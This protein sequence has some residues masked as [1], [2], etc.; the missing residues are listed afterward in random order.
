M[1]LIQMLTSQLGVSEGQ[2][3]GASGLIFKMA[4]EKLGSDDFTKVTSAVPGIDSLVSSAPASEGLSS[5][6]GG[7]MSSF[8]GGVG[9]AADLASIAGGFKDLNLDPALIE[10][11]IPIILSFV[12]SQGGD[13]VKNILLKVLK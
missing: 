3:K 12:Q 7:L 11:F 1:D 10:K 4:K 9:Q 2:A 13:V 8:G 5:A 6:L